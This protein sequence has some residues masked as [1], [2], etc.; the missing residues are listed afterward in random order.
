MTDGTTAPVRRGFV[1][2]NLWVLTIAA[3]LAV[4]AVLAGLTWSA[5]RADLETQ[6]KRIGEIEGQLADIE[7]KRSERVDADILESLGLSRNRLDGDAA[8]IDSLLDAAFTWD[9]GQAY[10]A[11]RERL[12]DRFGLTEDDVFL[13]E[14]VPPSRFNED[15]EGNRYY[16]IDTVGMNSSPGDDPDIEV[17]D[18]QAGDYTYAVLADV[19]ITSDAV[20]QD[21]ASNDI[22]V[23]RQM[24]LFATV[25]A[26]GAVSDLSGVPAS[27]V[28]RH[29]G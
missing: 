6:E 18:V 24:L 14:F 3:V 9:S 25:D 10:A 15:D 29:S 20:I 16:Y 1:R 23:S 17:V 7:Q 27:G 21:D 8:V 12:K 5:Q 2:R 11:A 22:A 28:T 19:E 26:E 4:V 13:R